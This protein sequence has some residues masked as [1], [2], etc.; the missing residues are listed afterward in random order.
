[1]DQARAKIFFDAFEGRRIDLGPMIDLKLQA[2]TGMAL[3]DTGYFNL[4]AFGNWKEHADHGCRRPAVFVQARHR[5]RTLSMLI[6]DPADGALDGGEFVLF[7]RQEILP[8]A[9]LLESDHSV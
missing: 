7:I 6:G 1:L 9:I 5:V 2:E 4:L 8:M 3:P